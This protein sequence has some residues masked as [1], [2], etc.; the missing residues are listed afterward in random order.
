MRDLLVIGEIQKGAVM[1]Y[2]SISVTPETVRKLRILA[3]EITAKT[4]KRTTFN[5]LINRGLQLI[6][7][8]LATEV[9]QS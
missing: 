4:G 8:D 1:A 3:A 6:R 7:D 2:N 5:E 9:T